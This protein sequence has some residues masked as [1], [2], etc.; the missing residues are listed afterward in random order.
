[1]SEQGRVV[2][3]TFRDAKQAGRWARN[4]AKRGEVFHDWGQFPDLGDVFPVES[5]RQYKVGQQIPKEGL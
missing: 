1:M 4:V 3:L 5:V 2:V